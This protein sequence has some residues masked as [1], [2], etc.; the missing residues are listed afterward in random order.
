MST[1]TIRIDEKLRRE[2]EKIGK[3]SHLPLSDIVR[4]SLR[5]Y[6]AVRQFYALRK[7]LVPLAQAQGF[8]TDEDIFK[9]FS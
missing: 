1:L 9:A 2:L 3:E 8:Y 5:R 4:D 7:K 6:V